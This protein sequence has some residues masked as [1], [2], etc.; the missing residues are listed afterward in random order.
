LTFCEFNVGP[1]VRC[2]VCVGGLFTC[3]AHYVACGGSSLICCPIC[4]KVLCERHVKC[5]CP[6]A[7]G[8]PASVP[9]LVAPTVVAV[10]VSGVGSLAAVAGGSDPVVAPA[11]VSVSGLS[12]SSCMAMGSRP[13]V[14]PAA[15]NTP[16]SGAL[17]AVAIVPCCCG[18]CGFRLRPV[19]GQ[20]GCGWRLCGPF[21]W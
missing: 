17:A 11:G 9:T 18:C 13:V 3:P 7:V 19:G 2:D 1:V 6:D 8:V 5:V 4:L 20:Y 15:M 16:I 12:A 10:S 14:A 21:C